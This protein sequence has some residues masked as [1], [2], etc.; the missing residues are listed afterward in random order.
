[1]F[2]FVFEARKCIFCYL[3]CMLKIMRQE[4]VGTLWNGTKPSL[5]LAANPAIQ[6]MVYEAIKRHIQATLQQT[7][8]L[9]FI[10]IFLSVIF[11]LDSLILTL[12]I[13]KKIKDFKISAVLSTCTSLME[14]IFS[15]LY[16]LF[17]MKTAGKNIDAKSNQFL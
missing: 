9:I 3:D 17:L 13:A 2:L 11:L 14:C 4:G 8:R 10:D 12:Q 6:F 15:K 5:V 7:V 1:M 16:T